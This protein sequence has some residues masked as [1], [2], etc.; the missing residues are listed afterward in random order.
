MKQD[1]IFDWS[2]SNEK[3]RGSLWYAIA[4]S[5][6]IGWVVWAILSRQYILAF[7]IIL[8]AWVYLFVEN[9]SDSEVNVSITHLGIRVNSTFYDFSKIHSFSILYS[10]DQAILLR[11][12]LSTRWI[13]LLDL[14]IDNAIAL[15]VKNILLEYSH[16]DPEQE[17]GFVDK[18]IAFL[19]L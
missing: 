18:I 13:K 7:L 14:K 5:A 9:N 10:Q 6:V 1:S 15:S 11:L 8:M 3:D 16:E 2:F 12:I 19:K 4:L 17:F